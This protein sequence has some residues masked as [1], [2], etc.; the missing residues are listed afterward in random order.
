MFNMQGYPS[1]FP[2]ENLSRFRAV[3]W[4]HAPPLSSLY[5]SM[6]A[7]QTHKIGNFPGFRYYTN[8]LILYWSPFHFESRMPMN[9]IFW[10]Q[11]GCNLVQKISESAW[12]LAVRSTDSR[13]IP[14]LLTK[15]LKPLA[16]TEVVSRLQ[17]QS[18]PA[19]GGACGHAPSWR[20][21]QSF[22]VDLGVMIQG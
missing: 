5:S 6:Q 3:L 17:S 20:W 19:D 10:M 4:Q 11:A 2:L 22:R 14:E 16:R 1:V 12:W 21:T 18:P 8:C 13:I 15:T 9:A 7:R